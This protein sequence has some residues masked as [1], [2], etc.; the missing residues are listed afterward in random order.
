MRHDFID[1]YDSEYNKE[2]ELEQYKRELQEQ[3]DHFDIV[4]FGDDDEEEQI[5]DVEQQQQ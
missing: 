2:N 4:D 5:Q 1:Q 3:G